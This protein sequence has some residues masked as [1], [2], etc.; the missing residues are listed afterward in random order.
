[1]FKDLARKVGAVRAVLAAFL[2][3]GLIHELVISLPARSG[4]GLPTFYFVMQCLGVFVERSGFGRRIGLGRG[5]TGWCF[6]ALLTGGPAFW[7]F[8]PNFVRNV[9]LPMLHAIGAT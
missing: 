1:M 8:P 4:Y 5:L 9:I 3:S 2:V 6:V 7:L